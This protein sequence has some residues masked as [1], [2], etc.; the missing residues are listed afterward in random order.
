MDYLHIY[1]ISSIDILHVLARQFALFSIVT[2]N[3]GKYNM[4][5]ID[6]E[7]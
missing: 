7:D 5:Q 1:V 4:E 6:Y 3:Y 2:D